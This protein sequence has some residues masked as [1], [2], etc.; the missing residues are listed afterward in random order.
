MVDEMMY[1][2]VDIPSAVLKT[3]SSVG[4]R[5]SVEEQHREFQRC[6]GG[7]GGESGGWLLLHKDIVAIEEPRET[8]TLTPIPRPSAV[9]HIRTG[10]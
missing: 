3:V 2:I 7:V 10:V 8:V 4:V 5:G 1:L 6:T 9:T